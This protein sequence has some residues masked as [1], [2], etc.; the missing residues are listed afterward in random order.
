MG[1]VSFCWSKL[2]LSFF[3]NGIFAQAKHWQVTGTNAVSDES[4]THFRVILVHP[5]LRGLKLLHTAKKY[6][7]Q[8]N[9]IANAGPNTG[10]T[11]AE[12]TKWIASPEDNLS[13]FVDI[14]TDT[15]NYIATPRYFP[16][17]HGAF[18]HYRTEGSHIVYLASRTGFRIYV[19]YG[20]VSR[21]IC[22]LVLIVV[23]S[24]HYA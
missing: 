24:G 7:W 17:I 2:C 11:D 23:T 9:W 8:I 4:A 21:V 3:F 16:A 15:C 19:V 10:I 12:H 13:V 18:E 6:N 5:H 1:T 20:S 14:K 22:F